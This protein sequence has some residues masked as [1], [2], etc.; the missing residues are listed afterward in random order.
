MTNTRMQH[1]IKILTNPQNKNKNKGDADRPRYHLQPRECIT[2]K[3]KATAKHD[4][5]A[6]KN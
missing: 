5:I 6:Q 4:P 2:P 1:A 3:A